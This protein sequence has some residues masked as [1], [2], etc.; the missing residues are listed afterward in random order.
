SFQYFG[1][2]L[3]KP[4]QVF[5]IWNTPVGIIP[6]EVYLIINILCVL[7]GIALVIFASKMTK[8]SK[9]CRTWTLRVLPVITLTEIVSFYKGWM[10]EGDDSLIQHVL[11]FVIGTI[12]LGGICTLIILA[13]TSEY[14]NNFFSRKNLDTVE[15]RV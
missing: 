10:S 2:M 13:Y 9:A 7:S 6:G 5:E 8:R 12:S 1:W 14:M 11:A 15:I 3:R 4:N